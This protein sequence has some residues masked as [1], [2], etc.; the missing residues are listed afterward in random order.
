MIASASLAARN[1]RAAPASSARE[2][3][4]GRRVRGPQRAIMLA[5]VGALMLRL[6]SGKVLPRDGD[7]ILGTH[8]C[9]ASGVSGVFVSRFQRPASGH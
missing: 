1:G 2:P 3:G 6:A 8:T 9:S 5:L 7:A 4:S